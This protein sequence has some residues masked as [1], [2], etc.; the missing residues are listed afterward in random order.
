[1]RVHGKVVAFCALAV[2]VSE[3]SAFATPKASPA[4]LGKTQRDMYSKADADMAPVDA[5]WE[6]SS[7]I[8]VQGTTL[9]TCSLPVSVDKAQLMLKSEGRPLT[10]RVDLYHGPDYIPWKCGVYTENGLTRPVN[11]V[12]PTPLTGNTLAMQNTGFS[13][14]PFYACAK[15]DAGSPRLDNFVK[16]L[17]DEGSAKLVQGGAV[18]T[19][20]FD[21]SVESVQILLKS[22][23]RHLKA[24]IELLNGPNNLKQSFEVYSSN[25]YKR[26]FMAVI[27]TPGDGNVIRIVNTATLE[28][29][30]TAT[31]E[32]YVVASADEAAEEGLTW[33]Q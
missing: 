10:S 25:G 16:K 8:T 20:P 30:L 12:V 28:Y 33:T 24:R 3:C 17:T 11:L 18:S 32:P 13:E 7:S 5:L 2:S 29:P 21:H 26:P 22:D 19:T 15:V 23:T 4:F 6:E 14:F 9:R 1:M 31:V 27:N